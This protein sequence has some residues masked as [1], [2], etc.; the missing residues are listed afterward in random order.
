MVPLKKIEDTQVVL[1]EIES[2]LNKLRKRNEELYYK[3]I[4]PFEEIIGKW[5]ETQKER[6]VVIKEFFQNSQ[7]SR[8]TFEL[9]LH[10]M[11]QYSHYDGSWVNNNPHRFDILEFINDYLTKFEGFKIEDIKVKK[12]EQIKNKIF[13]YY[14]ININDRN[15]H[16]EFYIV[17]PYSVSPEDVCLLYDNENN[18]IYFKW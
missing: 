10:F 11:K 8:W 16:F 6:P 3:F 4:T 12:V 9:N 1:Q 14:D 5:E 17:S 15:Y 2:S 13:A 18:K 7:I